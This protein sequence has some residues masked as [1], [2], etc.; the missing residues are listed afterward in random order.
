MLLQSPIRPM[1]IR[2]SL[3]TD[4]AALTAIYR[5]HVLH[6]SAS[7]ETEP[8]DEREMSRRRADLIGRGMPHLVLEMDGI[9][10][11]Y[12]YA[13]PYR[14]R[15]AYRDTVEDS[16]YLVPDAVG[17]GYGSALMAALIEAC[18]ASVSAR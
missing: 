12:A 7:F 8:P 11:G 1:R 17:R 5:H 13:G 18:T 6:G 16:V 3:E 2:P 14:P 9:L 4:L 15:A 10:R